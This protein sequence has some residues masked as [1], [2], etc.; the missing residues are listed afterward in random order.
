MDDA[1]LKP[2]L[3]PVFGGSGG[4][5]SS[6]FVLPVLFR[7][8]P[9]NTLSWYFFR[10]N[11]SIAESASSAS[12]GIGGL[13]LLG[14]YMRFEATFP[15]RFIF[16]YYLATPQRRPVGKGGTCLHLLIRPRIHTQ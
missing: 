8:G 13:V 2:N 12:N 3:L 10:M 14:L 4:G 7:A 6:E 11:L 16:Y 15:T 5:L 9:S 1:D